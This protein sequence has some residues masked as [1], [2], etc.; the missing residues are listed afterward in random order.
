MAAK[1]PPP[2]KKPHVP[3][4]EVHPLASERIGGEPAEEDP[5]TA[6]E[7][8]IIEVGSERLEESMPDTKTI[9]APQAALRAEKP[10]PM[11]RFDA[12]ARRRHRRIRL[13]KA[14]L[15]ASIISR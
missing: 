13:V 11:S 1:R 6:V 5:E 15:L 4:S 14:L 8:T 3:H 7:V 10:R 12:I 2:V 9:E